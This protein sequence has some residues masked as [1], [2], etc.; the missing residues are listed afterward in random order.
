MLINQDLF[1]IKYKAKEKKALLDFF[2]WRIDF[3]IERENQQEEEQ[4]DGYDPNDFFFWT[5]SKSIVE[6]SEDHLDLTKLNGRKFISFLPVYLDFY[7]KTNVKKLASS[8]VK[9]LLYFSKKV[10]ATL[11][12]LDEI[13]YD[14]SLEHEIELHETQFDSRLKLYENALKAIK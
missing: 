8:D 11:D 12:L 3:D 13:N 7:F 9:F 10:K 5:Y 1:K 2:N 4:D 14:S 6:E